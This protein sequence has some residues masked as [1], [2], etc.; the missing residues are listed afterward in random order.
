MAKITRISAGGA[1]KSSDSSKR[2]K[3][4]NNSPNQ[5]QKNLSKTQ[6]SPEQIPEKNS[7]KN[8]KI[9]QKLAKLAE[10]MQKKA[11]K[12]EVKAQ[13]RAKRQEKRAARR[14]KLQ[15]F[16]NK[17]PV[18]IITFPFRII[19]APILKFAKYCKESWAEL[20]QVQWPNRKTTWKIVGIVLIYTAIFMIFITIL[21]AI[22]GAG[23]NQLLKK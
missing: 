22:I 2:S 14:E 12:A 19:L 21:D 5:N 10:K 17:K 3:S 20:R 6:K 1:K 9:D 13:K 11:K 18:K 16:A 7:E 4:D 23:F 8:S 15:K